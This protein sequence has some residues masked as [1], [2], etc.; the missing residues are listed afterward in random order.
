ML[1]TGCRLLD[2]VNL[3]EVVHQADLNRLFCGPNEHYR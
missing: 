2:A 3:V 1:L